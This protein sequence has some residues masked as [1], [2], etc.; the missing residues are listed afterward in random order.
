MAVLPAPHA[1]GREPARAGVPL[2]PRRRPRARRR[3]H[4]RHR[5]RHHHAAPV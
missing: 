3:P 1:R 5:D 4:A 2:A